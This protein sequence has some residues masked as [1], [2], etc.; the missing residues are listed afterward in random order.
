MIL[1]DDSP[2]VPFLSL[3][4]SMKNCLILILSLATR[5]W[6]LFSTS[7][8]KFMYGTALCWAEGWKLLTTEMAIGVYK[9]RN[10]LL[11]VLFWNSCEATVDDIFI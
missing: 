5:A 6:I 10:Y 8:S 4:K 11:L 2:T 3:S 1:T 7:S 9:L